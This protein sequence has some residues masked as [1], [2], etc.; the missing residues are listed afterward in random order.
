MPNFTDV[1]EQAESQPAQIVFAE[2]LLGTT[3]KTK[4]ST[5]F[6]FPG[7]GQKPKRNIP[8]KQGG[9]SVMS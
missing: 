4:A 9:Y 3:Q 5:G 8:K 2:D 7:E 6:V 1:L